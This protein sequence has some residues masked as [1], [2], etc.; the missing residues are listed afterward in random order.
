MLNDIRIHSFRSK[1]GA[2]SKCQPRVKGKQFT[3][4]MLLQIETEG[5]AAVLSRFSC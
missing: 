5:E 4:I 2:A 1:G 3:I